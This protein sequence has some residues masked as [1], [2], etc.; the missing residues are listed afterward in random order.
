MSIIPL[1]VDLLSGTHRLPAKN[2]N[3]KLSRYH[4]PESV[5]VSGGTVTCNYCDE[6]WMGEIDPG[7]EDAGKW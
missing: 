2:L 3:F 6:F 5:N 7:A 1:C 4:Y